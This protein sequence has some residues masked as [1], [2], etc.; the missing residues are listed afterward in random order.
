M[1]TST[2]DRRDPSRG[3]RLASPSRGESGDD[4]CAA[5]GHRRRRLGCHAPHCSQ[6]RLV[7]HKA[8]PTKHRHARR[9]S[10]TLRA[11]RPGV[12]AANQASS[13]LVYRRVCRRRFRCATLPPP[14]S[15]PPHR[16]QDFLPPPPSPTQLSCPPTSPSVALAVDTL[17]TTTLTHRP[18]TIPP[19]PSRP[20]R[21]S[22]HVIR[23]LTCAARGCAAWC[24][25]ARGLALR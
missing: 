8:R 25:A 21:R 19:Q 9:T 22:S 20:P 24:C 11:P 7:V 4:G 17:V 16:R 15:P 14:P 1:R 6:A 23:G 13:P 5:E 3:P 2:S 18:R 10:A 12:K